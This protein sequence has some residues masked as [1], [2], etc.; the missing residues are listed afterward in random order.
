[1][2][3]VLVV[4]LLTGLDNLQAAAGI[5]MLPLRE[6]RKW[7]IALTFALFESAMPLIGLLIGNHLLAVL[8]RFSEW[9]APICL[10]CCGLLIVGLALRER[11]RAAVTISNSRWVLFGLPLSLSFDNLLAGIGIGSLGLPLVPSA[12]IIGGISG[13]MSLL[14]MFVGA[15]IRTALSEKLPDQIELVSGAWLVLAALLTVYLDS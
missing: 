2:W 8:G 9:V 1:M 15:R 12:V 7:H 3:A 13:T 11:T 14:G 6:A 10:A 5:G 4:G